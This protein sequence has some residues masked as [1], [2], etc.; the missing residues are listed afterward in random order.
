MEE[1]KRQEECTQQGKSEEARGDRVVRMR[2][3]EY[4]WQGRR[5]VSPVKRDHECATRGGGGGQPQ[6]WS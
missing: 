4:G 5:G 6:S 1:G 2:S 3:I